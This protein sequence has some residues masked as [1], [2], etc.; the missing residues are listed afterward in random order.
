MVHAINVFVHRPSISNHM[1]R[2]VEE[3]TNICFR[4]CF[5][6]A[7][8]LSHVHYCMI[9]TSPFFAVLQVLFRRSVAY[10]AHD[11]DVEVYFSLTSHSSIYLHLFASN[12]FPHHNSSY[13][14]MERRVGEGVNATPGVTQARINNYPLKRSYSRGHPRIPYRNTHLPV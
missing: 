8:S 13:I 1:H 11:K 4:D 12:V 10:N 6:N 3:M 7:S 14:I 5:K 9:I 2:S